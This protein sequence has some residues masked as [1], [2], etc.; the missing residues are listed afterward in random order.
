M[1]LMFFILSVGASI[2][3]TYAKHAKEFFWTFLWINYR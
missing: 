2:D 1:Y 3:I